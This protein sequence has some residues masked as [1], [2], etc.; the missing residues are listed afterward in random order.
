PLADEYSATKLISE[1]GTQRKWSE[2]DINRDVKV[3]QDQRLYTVADLRLLGPEAWREVPLLPI[4]KELL[5]RAAWHGVGRAK[6]KE[7][8]KEEKNMKKA[9][10]MRYKAEEEFSSSSSSSES[11]MERDKVN[12]ENNENAKEKKKADKL[13]KKEA[14]RAEKDLENGEHV[15][16]EKIGAPNGTVLP[17]GI[18]LESPLA[19][20]APQQ[21]R[22]LAAPVVTASKI[23]ATASDGKT[24]E[25][26]RWCPHKGVDL[27]KGPLVGTRII[28]PKHRWEFDLAR[29]GVCVD[30]P[31][32]SVNACVVND[33]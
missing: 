5:R 25:F 2:G 8:K 32:K 17:E 23:K 24:Y 6:L 7:K 28:C 11:E 3:M 1:I 18:S 16:N 10:K 12:K 20:G 29:G 26:D 4:V 9:A 21:P 19:N 14:K 27:A 33:W 22:F 13:E 31:G 30:K 15:L